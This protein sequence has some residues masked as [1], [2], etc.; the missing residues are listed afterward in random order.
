VSN[1][2]QHL[3]PQYAQQFEDVAVACAYYAR[4]P[5]PEAVFDLVSTLVTDRPRRVL[6]LGAGTGDLTLG[7]AA[8]ADAIEAV[9]PSS[10]MLEVARV[11]QKAAGAPANIDWLRT[12]AEEHSYHGPYG[13]VVAAE[14]LHWMSWEQVF[15]AIA[16]SLSP[17]GFLIIVCDRLLVGLPWRERERELI[18]RYST[19]RE[20]RPY[21]LA[22]E[23][24]TRELFTE[25]GRKECSE[26]RFSQSIDDY[27]ESFHS[28]NGFSRERMGA[29]AADF[30]RELRELVLGHM[31]S[32][33]VEAKVVTTV[34][35]GRPSDLGCC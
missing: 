5:Y 21:D 7:L 4:P 22:S 6:E 12:T 14:S 3:G 27:V 1:K 9:E 23:L 32:G 18:A 24:A 2:P 10:A 16:R 28:R 34:I 29:S 20:F 13:A 17:S 33:R 15:P 8:R 35:W 19:N 31:P 11:R 30:D 26:P 25:A